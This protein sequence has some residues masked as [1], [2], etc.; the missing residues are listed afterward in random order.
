M[1]SV[2]VTIDPY[3]KPTIDAQGF[4]GGLCSQV[5]DTLTQKLGGNA[6][7]TEKPEMHEVSMEQEQ[8]QH[9]GGY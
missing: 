9:L 6:T 7:V 8:H 2:K 5:T 4:T 3:G 1:K